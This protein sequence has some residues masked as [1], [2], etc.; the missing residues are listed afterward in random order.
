MS[1]NEKDFFF[2]LVAVGLIAGYVD[3]ICIEELKKA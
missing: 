2:F 3:R 1:Q